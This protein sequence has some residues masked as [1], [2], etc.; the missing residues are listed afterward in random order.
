[1]LDKFA[2]FETDLYNF[3]KE[4]NQIIQTPATENLPTNIIIEQ[5]PIKQNL[6]IDKLL[7]Q[8]KAQ[9]EKYIS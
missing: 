3:D 6:D 7:E 4:L 2:E 1:M 8:L 9:G 5:Q